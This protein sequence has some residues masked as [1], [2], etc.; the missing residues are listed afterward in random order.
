M[1]EEEHDL[2]G[3]KEPSEYESDSLDSSESSEE[4]DTARCWNENEEQ[5]FQ[6]HKSLMNHIVLPRFLPQENSIDI[7]DEELKLLEH[8]NSTL[9]NFANSYGHIP[10][11]TIEMFDGLKRMYTTCSPE[12]ILK[13]IRRLV[14]GETFAM[15]VRRQNC[16]LTIHMPETNGD[17][18]NQSDRL[19]VA[20]FPGSVNPNHHAQHNGCDIEVSQFS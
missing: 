4:D 3:E 6:K 9:N 12:A 1:N 2:P 5:K 18:A 16:A 14:P 17:D 11:S 10:K 8:M 19:I 20:T 13:E 15:F 7:I